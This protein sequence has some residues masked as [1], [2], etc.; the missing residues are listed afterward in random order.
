[1]STLNIFTGI[2]ILFF[3]LG[4]LT[5]TVVVI[6][7]KLHEIYKMKWL[8]WTLLLTGISTIMFGIAWSA[9]SVLEGVPRSGS[10]GMLFFGGGGLV[11][12]AIARRF[13]L[14]DGKEKELTENDAENA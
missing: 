8:S 2:E 7:Y 12:L 14:K 4:F 5:A 10:M 9:S 6:C 11:F 1:M 3:S 13:I